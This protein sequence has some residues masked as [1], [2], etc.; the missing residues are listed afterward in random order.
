MPSRKPISETHA[1]VPPILHLLAHPLRW[2]VVN[3]LK[4]SDLRDQE[5]VEGTLQPYNLVSYHLRMLRTAGLVSLRKSDAD[6]RDLYYSLDIDKLQ[7]EYQSAAV[8]LFP[9]WGWQVQTETGHLVETKRVLFLC[10]HNSARSQMAEAMLRHFG[11]NAYQ[12]ASAGSHPQKVHPQAIAVMDDM[13]ID[14][15]GQRAKH[16]NEFETVPFDMIITVC[17]R[18][19]EEK[20]A[21]QTSAVQIHWSIPDPIRT[22]LEEQGR[23]RFISAAN[24]LKKRINFFLRLQQAGRLPLNQ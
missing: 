4:I 13:G 22:D 7:E 11:G 2:Q 9:G 23:Q 14:M 16:L 8:Q 24:E 1:Q 5:L 10:T 3:L 12:T 15:R 17:D 21:F 6:S 19:R 20:L 18:V